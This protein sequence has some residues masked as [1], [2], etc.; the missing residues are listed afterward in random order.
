MATIDPNGVLIYQ[1]TDNYTPIQTALNLAQSNLSSILGANAQIVKVSS[2][3]NRNAEAAARGSVSK[4]NPFVAWRADAAD[5]LQLEYTTNGSTWRTIADKEYYDA[6]DTGW[7]ACTIG[8]SGWVNVAAEP[9]Q[10]RRIGKQVYMRGSAHNNT[11]AKSTTVTMGT[12]PTGFRPSQRA[13]FSGTLNTAQNL[14]IRIET[15]GNITAGWWSDSA[16]ATT[17]SWWGFN[18]V[19][20]TIN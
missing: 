1:D 11:L 15:N 8:G 18:N 4:A 19:V 20:Y 13:A 6:Q 10:V 2:V 16:T 3:G 17:G 7:V 9:V 12:V 14:F 5:G